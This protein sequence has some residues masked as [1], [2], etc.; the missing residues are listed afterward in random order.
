MPS[1]REAKAPTTKGLQFKQMPNL[2]KAVVLTSNPNATRSATEVI[3]DP[4]CEAVVSYTT[5]YKGFKSADGYCYPGSGMSIS[6]IAFGE[7]GDVYFQDIVASYSTG[8]YVKGSIES[9]TEVRI[10][11]PQT[12]F[13]LDFGGG[14]VFEI[15]ANL[16]KF[17]YSETDGGV[18]I[19]TSIA[20]N[21]Y[22]TY[23]IGADGEEV[24]LNLP[25]WE[26][27]ANPEVDNLFEY[28]IGLISPYEYVDDNG[29]TAQGY[30][31]LGCADVNQVKK[32]FG[33]YATY[34]P[35]GLEVEEWAM[36]ADNNYSLVNVAF[37]NANQEV[38]VVGINEFDPNAAIVGSVE[39]GQI[40]FK[41]PQYMGWCSN[42]GVPVYFCTGKLAD[43]GY[44]FEGAG[45]N[46]DFVF[47]F[48]K[49]NNVMKSQNPAMCLIEN[50]AEDYSYPFRFFMNPTIKLQNIAETYACP[51][52][53]S[54]LMCSPYDDKEGEGYIVWDIPS[55]NVE[56]ALIPTD[57]MYYNLY[58]DGELFP[59]SPNDYMFVEEY[60]ED[61]PYTYTDNYDINVGGSTHW[62]YYYIDGVETMGVQSFYAADNGMIYS[63]NHITYNL[64]TSETTNEGGAGET[65]GVEAVEEASVVGSY[66]T[67]LLGQRVSNPD[68]GL[69]IKTDV[70]SNGTVRSTKVMIRK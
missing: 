40:T 13:Y 66:Y 68:S 65:T 1:P 41:A 9:P 33:Q 19:D 35:D 2:D 54:L 8:T 43:N 42:F 57:R 12:V 7:E 26:V 18:N 17:T 6:N 60:M 50:A 38:Y 63:S 59:L 48:D 32:Y 27:P 61:I 36:V 3:V 51:R 45:F 67:N 31:W 25:D 21:N 49:A 70:L 16:L 11:F 55:I 30:Y 56:N 10:D 64:E 39:D 34:V 44:E 58:V 5:D 47:D 15:E 62:I 14:Y 53:P 69:Y 22:V 29:E 4:G 24:T 46:S 20:E 52:D 37:D 28:A 23:T